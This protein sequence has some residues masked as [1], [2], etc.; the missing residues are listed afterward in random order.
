MFKHKELQHKLYRHNVVYKLTCFCGSAYIAQIRRNLQLRL[1]E[2]NP[3]TNPNQHSDVN[4]HLL[5]NPNHIIDFSDP[6][7]LCSAYNT[8]ELLIKEILLIQQYQSDINADGSSFHFI[9][10]Q[11]LMW[12]EHFV[13][14][15]KF[16]FFSYSLSI[17]CLFFFLVTLLFW[18]LCLLHV[19]FSPP[20]TLSL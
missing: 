9:C 17:C 7:V 6:Q 15:V 13:N 16:L 3:A 2:H 12:L 5:K 10:I 1:P 20:L 18:N 4:K 19:L 11:Q 8:K 14:N